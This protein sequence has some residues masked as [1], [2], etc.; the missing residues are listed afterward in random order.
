[1][2]VDVDDEA[3]PSTSTST[4]GYGRLQQVAADVTKSQGTAA[5][6]FETPR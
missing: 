1:M 2:L 5:A 6:L 3:A 4:I